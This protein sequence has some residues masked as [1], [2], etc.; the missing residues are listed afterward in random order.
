M[1]AR[2]EDSSSGHEEAVIQRHKKGGR[3]G[4]KHWEGC[5][6][7]KSWTSSVQDPACPSAALW[8]TRACMF[9]MFYFHHLEQGHF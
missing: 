5:Q 2:R 4:L 1:V 6:H 9:P 3:G 8:Y 7:F